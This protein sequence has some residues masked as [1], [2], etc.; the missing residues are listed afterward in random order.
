MS[1]KKIIIVSILAVIFLLITGLVVFDVTKSIDLG[2]YN[3]LMNLR[4][5]FLDKYFVFIT[6]F[7]D[8][9]FICGLVFGVILFLRNKYSLLYGCLA[10]DCALTNKIVKHIIRRDR[11]DVLKLIKQGGF[12]YP[13]GHSMI[14]MCMYGCLIYIVLKKIKNKYLKW[15]LVFMLSLLIVSVGLSRIYVGVHYLSDVIS[16]FIL[17][18]IILILYIELI[19][20]YFVRGN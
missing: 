10:I 4:C 20:K 11:P 19:N 2:F 6:K 7:G 1:K 16:G 8:V 14:S 18:L 5:D 15:F 13:S 17:G 3:S 12:S 9:A